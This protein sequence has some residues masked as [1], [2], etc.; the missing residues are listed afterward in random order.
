M[1][2]FNW[3]KQQ[4]IFYKISCRDDNIKSSYIGHTTN[5][6]QRMKDHKKAI[7]NVNHRN[8]HLLVYKTIRDNSGWDNWKMQE[9][10]SQICSSRTVARQVEQDFINQL[11]PDMNYALSVRTPEQKLEYSKQYIIE[12]ADKKKETDKQYQL[13]NAEILYEKAK[14]Y[15][16]KN[17][18][19]IKEQRRQAYLKKTKPNEPSPP[20]LAEENYGMR[21][22]QP[23]IET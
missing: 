4:V 16:L 8:Y 14:Q 19:K 10:H 1:S 11:K 13:K 6:T 21:N 5:F 3:E 12:N 17:S 15:R 18:D 2:K 23:M 22:S 9:I 20:S 7:D